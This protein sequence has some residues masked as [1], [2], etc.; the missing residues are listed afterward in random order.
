MR[1]RAYELDQKLYRDYQPK[2]TTSEWLEEHMHHP[3]P[4]E[5]LF[6]EMPAGWKKRLS[7]NESLRFH[8]WMMKREMFPYRTAVS[9]WLCGSCPD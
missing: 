9:V 7:R 4:D 6:V 5:D 2:P 8:Y 3:F 1:T